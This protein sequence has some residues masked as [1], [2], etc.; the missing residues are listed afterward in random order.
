M[1]VLTQHEIRSVSG[2]IS[3]FYPTLLVGQI[4]VSVA[5]TY[6]TVTNIKTNFMTYAGAQTIVN[7]IT[8]PV[9]GIPIGTIA[10]TGAGALAGYYAYHIIEAM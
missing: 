9:L 6:A 2:G 1:K 10:M 8:F 7:I 4:F 3:L 5:S